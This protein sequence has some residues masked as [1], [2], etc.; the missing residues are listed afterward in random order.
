MDIISVTLKTHRVQTSKDIDAAA[1][2]EM[3]LTTD[4]AHR[5]VDT[6]RERFLV[7]A[8][9]GGNVS[10]H[11][12]NINTTVLFPYEINSDLYEYFSAW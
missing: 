12:M 7:S 2:H 10:R 4:Q 1:M 9:D 3:I 11:N 6:L 8:D 5:M